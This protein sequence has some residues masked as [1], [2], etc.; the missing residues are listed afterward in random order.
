MIVRS[1]GLLT[2]AVALMG[3]APAPTPA[4]QPPKPARPS[5]QDIVAASPPAAWKAV[6]PNDIV[7]MTLA[8]GNAV[9]YMLA[10]AYAPVHVANRNIE[11]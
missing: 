3:A 9:T 11:R 10:P 4:P 6:D 1:L 7:V 8:D 5:A 2:L